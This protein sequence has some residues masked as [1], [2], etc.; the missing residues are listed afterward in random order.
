MKEL[1]NV[2]RLELYNYKFGNYK[3]MREI[4]FYRGIGDILSDYSLFLHIPEGKEEFKQII[5]ILAK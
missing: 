5:D 1:T 2:K 3:E 4:N